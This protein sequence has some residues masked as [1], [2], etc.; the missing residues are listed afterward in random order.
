M[1]TVVLDVD[2]SSRDVHENDYGFVVAGGDG[3]VDVGDDGGGVDDFGDEVI[4]IVVVPM[5][6]RVEQVTLLEEE[7]MT[8]EW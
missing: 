7:L 2:G 4:V 1:V 8:V 3:S 6:T 5:V